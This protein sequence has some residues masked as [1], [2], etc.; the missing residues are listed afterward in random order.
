[1][2]HRFLPFGRIALA[3]GAATAMLALSGC[4]LAPN[5]EQPKFVVPD[6]WHGQAPFARATPADT[7]MPMD[8]WTLFNDPLL[9]S[10]E[11]KLTASNPDLQASAERFIQAR[12]MV[13]KARSELL[14]HLALAAGASDNKQSADRLFRYKGETTA[15]DESYGGLA[16]WEPDFWSAIRN[17]VRAQKQYAQEKAADFALS[18]LSLQ[19]ELASDYVELRGYDAQIAIYEQSIGYYEKALKITQNQLANQ[20]APRLDVARAQT[21]LYNTQAAKLDVEAARAVTEHAIAVLTNTAP[22]GFHIASQSRMLSAQPAIPTGI[23]SELLQRRP[24]IA[25]SEREMAQANREIGIARAA[26]YPHISLNVGGGFAQNGFD[27]ANLA[28]SLWTYGAS[29]ELPLFEGGLR[30][31]ELQ[32]SWSG[33]RETRDTYRSKVLN[34]FREV[35]DGLSRTD[36]LNLENNT[37]EKAVRATLDTQNMTMTLYQG[38]VGTYLDAL[39]SQVQTLDT[40]IH[41]VE[42]ATRLFQADVGLI[43]ALGGGWNVHL[44]PTMDQTLSIEPLQYSDLHHPAPVGGVTISQDPATFENLRATNAPGGPVIPSP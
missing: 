37:L 23:P 1:M 12:A 29:F 20:A 24:D 26:F 27:L 15:T 40:R 6:S 16:S 25:A 31:A 4:D 17:H 11:A 19:A 34:A 35:E 13:V 28:N 38:G 44:M 22:S 9:T 42:V 10:L 30:R 36:R 33:Y 2:I 21:Q 7:V 5:Y 14:P 39:F 18:R 41:Q 43:R 8:W 3:C 32:R